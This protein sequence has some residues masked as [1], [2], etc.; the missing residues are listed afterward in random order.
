MIR[1][2]FQDL[3][4]L[5][6]ILVIPNISDEEKLRRISKAIVEIKKKYNKQL[7]G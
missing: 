1:E 5:E 2:F 7:F 3:V 6:Y 4:S